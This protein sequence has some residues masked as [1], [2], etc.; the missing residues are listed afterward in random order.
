MARLKAFWL[1]ALL[2]APMGLAQLSQSGQITVQ[3]TGLGTSGIFLDH[4]G[5]TGTYTA[6][7]NFNDPAT[8]E[9]YLNAVR[10][11][12]PRYAQVNVNNP[13]IKIWKNG[14]A[15][16]LVTA[17]STGVGFPLGRFDVLFGTGSTSLTVN[18]GATGVALPGGGYIEFAAN[19]IRIRLKVEPQDAPSGYNQ[20]V[21]FSLTLVP[22]P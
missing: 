6:N 21:S 8:W 12:T 14:P 11:G 13:I 7:F 22:A 5:F 4:E 16:V 2:L 17:T 15:Q 3:V 19:S 20:T 9:V 18:L 1:W 10:T